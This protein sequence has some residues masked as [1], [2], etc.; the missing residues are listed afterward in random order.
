ME[1]KPSSQDK[2]GVVAATW[3]MKEESQL[4]SPAHVSEVRNASLLTDT[5]LLVVIVVG[6]DDKGG[7]GSKAVGWPLKLFARA[8]QVAFLH[9]GG[10]LRSR[11]FSEARL[12]I[13]R[14]THFSRAHGS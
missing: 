10:R 2:V 5:R 9:R 12:L 11:K 3:S 1:N 4:G 6:D 7:V 14:A 13:S 8:D